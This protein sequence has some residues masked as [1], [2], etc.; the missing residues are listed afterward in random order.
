MTT[1]L[2]GKRAFVAGAGQGMGRQ[3]ALA[4]AAEGAEVIAASRTLGKMADLPKIS[5]A[6]APVELDLTDAQAV[7]RVAGES[8]EVDILVNCA[9]WVHTGT[10]LDCPPDEWLRSFDQ[11][12]H[13]CYHTIRNFLPGMVQRGSGSIVNIASVAGS[14]TGVP[15]RAAY[16]TSK[17]ALIGM[18]KAVARDFIASG[19]RC[20]A[21]CPGTTHSPSLQ[22]R[23]DEADDPEEALRMFISRQP[24]GR[25]GRVEEMAA[26]ALYLASDESG[27]MTGQCLVIDGG[28][29]L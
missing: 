7:E 3:I 4:F 1:R 16:G 6:I 24:M 20:N 27:F 25:L 8:G 12:V 17:A 13:A 14:I 18:T 2:E 9:A 15:M 10:I 21:L 22:S 19:V 23:I 26:A 5:A 28:Q 11:N 29:T